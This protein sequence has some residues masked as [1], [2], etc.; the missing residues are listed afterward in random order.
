[1]EYL[2]VKFAESRSVIVDEIIE[3]KTDQ[4]LELEA[5]SHVV[6]LDGSPDFYPESREFILRNTSELSPR[7]ISFEKT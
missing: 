2:L 1:M 6:T 4:V 3:G 7:E 5:G